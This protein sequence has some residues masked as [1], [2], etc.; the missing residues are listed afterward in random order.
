[1]S[2]PILVA[3]QLIEVSVDK[4]RRWFL[5]L[6][7]HPE[8]YQFDTHGG[9]TVTEGNFG[10]EGSKFQTKER[11]HGVPI[12]L[13]FEL[14]GVDACAFRFQLRRPPLPIWGSFSLEPI[15]DDTTRLSLEIGATAPIAAWF[16]LLP[17]VR[18]SVQGQ[19]QR[20]VDHIQT[21]MERATL[22]TT[23]DDV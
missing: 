14:T 8:R 4:A 9:F 10:Q 13:S 19:I 6:Q 21:S 20:E 1:M 3:Q 5:A 15:A 11:F 7:D 2:E 17:L 22:D 16:L 23:S 18:E 12:K